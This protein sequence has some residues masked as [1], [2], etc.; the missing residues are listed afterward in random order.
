MISA[1]KCGA[2]ANACKLRACSSGISTSRS[3]EQSIMALNWT[4]LADQIDL[5][6]AAT[7]RQ[8]KLIVFLGRKARSWRFAS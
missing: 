6:N 1:E 5:E 8:H 2:Y 3:L 7:G 4:A